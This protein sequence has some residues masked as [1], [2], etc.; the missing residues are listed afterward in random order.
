MDSRRARIACLLVLCGPAVAGPAGRLEICQEHP[1]YFRDGDKHVV[2]VGVSDRDLFSVWRNE[3][4]FSWQKY[5]DH[6]EAHHINYVR[7]DGCGWGELRTRSKYPAQFSDPSWPFSRTGPGKAVDGLPKF[8]LT[9]FDA[10][11]FA[12]RLKPFLRASARRGVYVE[13]TLFEGFRTQRRFAESLF[14]DENNTNRLGLAPRLMTSD[15]AL[16]NAPLVAIQHAYVDRVL[17]E[18]AEFGHLIYEISNETG[19]ERWVSH[20]IDYIH[21]HSTYPGRLVSAGE[22]TSAFDPRS[23]LNDVVVK[24]RGGGGLYATHRDVRNHHSALLRYRVGKPVIHNELKL[25]AGSYTARWYDP[26]RGNFLTTGTR[27]EGGARRLV[28]SPEF[29]QDCVLWIRSLAGRR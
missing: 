16:D 1:H 22:Q 18:T 25:A 8:D 5:L 4:G 14:A 11:Y 6:L 13:L 2:L 29:K 17:E 19:G 21:H 10:A 27:L 23:G 20:F 7:Q 24:H 12:E 3:K 28:R 15:S 26:K 9:R